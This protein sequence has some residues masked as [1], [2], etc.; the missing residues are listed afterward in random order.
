M[1][2]KSVIRLRRLFVSWVVGVIVTL[3]VAWYCALR[4]NVFTENRRQS[5]RSDGVTV[6]AIYDWTAAGARR[7][8]IDRKYQKSHSPWI[9]ENSDPEDLRELWT[10]LCAPSKEFSSKR[11]HRE[12]V[13]GDARGWPCLSLCATGN[14]DPISGSVSRIEFGIESSLTPWKHNGYVD[15]RILPLK[16]IWGGLL[17]DS[18]IF[19]G[20]VYLVVT[21]WIAGRRWKRHRSEQCL[22]CGYQ[23]LS[24]QPDCPE[25]GSARWKARFSGRS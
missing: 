6:I 25:C 1:A 4:V 8:N 18:L 17:I 20:T 24:S 12:S 10:I 14:R 15:P 22:V 21:V 5:Y 19:G 9:I 3:V 11:I 7:T 16:P 2:K 23:L 13:W